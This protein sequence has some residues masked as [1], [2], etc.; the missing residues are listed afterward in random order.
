ME[1]RDPFAIVP[2]WLA[3]LASAPALRLYVWIGA[4]YASGSAGTAWPSQETLADD[5]RTTSRSVRTWMD[6]LAQLGAIRVQHRPGTS[7]VTT[8]IARTLPPSARTPEADFRGTPEA[9]FRS[10][11]KPASGQ[12]GSRFPPNQKTHEPEAP[13]PPARAQG[14]GVGAVNPTKTAAEI[15]AEREQA[16]RDAVDHEA[17]K[18]AIARARAELESK[19]RHPSSGAT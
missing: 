1:Q 17:G 12:S 19:G 14:G 18:A 6:E 7:S 5:L 2:L 9:D 15:E 8:L 16:A 3:E 13:P 4:K 11:R 10:P